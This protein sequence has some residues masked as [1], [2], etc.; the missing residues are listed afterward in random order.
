MIFKMS[1]KHD[2]KK[3]RAYHAYSRDRKRRREKAI[4]LISNLFCD[5]Y[6][7]CMYEV[8]F[9]QNVTFGRV[10][11]ESKDFLKGKQEKI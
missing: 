1:L 2:R 11:R 9:S 5:G 7:Y 4:Y 10:F 6:S 3:P 8:S